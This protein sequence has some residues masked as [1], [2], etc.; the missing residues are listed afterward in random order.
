[1]PGIIA[2]QRK[3]VGEARQ[4]AAFIARRCAQAWLEDTDE[5]ILRG[6]YAVNGAVWIGFSE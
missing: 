5:V 6:Y 1:L 3:V 2:D 4:G